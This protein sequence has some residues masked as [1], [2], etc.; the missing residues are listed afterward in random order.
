V[1]LPRLPFVVVRHG[2]TD[3]NCDAVIAGRIEAELTETG[4]AGARALGDWHWP[5]SMALF[6]SPQKRARDTARLGFPAMEAEVMEGLRERNWGCYEGKPLAD[7]PA[8][9][10]TPEGGETWADMLARVAAEITKAQHR[11]PN[12]L[13]VF[14]AHSGVI[15]AVRALTDQLAKGANSINTTPYLYIP[16]QGSW[17]ETCPAKTDQSWAPGPRPA[18][19]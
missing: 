9:E 8:V 2:Q 17:L 3:A 14:V 13:P 1:I 5:D 11:L 16:H 19:I 12:A 7:M 4:Q 10:H 18:T 6:V 15:H